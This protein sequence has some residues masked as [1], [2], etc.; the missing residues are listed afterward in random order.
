[1]LDAQA[2][3]L[4]PAAPPPT[5]A[6]AALRELPLGAVRPRGWLLDQ[7]R[8]QAD[9]LTG[10]LDDLWAD[11][12]PNSAWLGGGGEDWER[13]PYY[14]DGLLPLAHLLGDARLLAKAKVWVEAMLASQREDGFF[15]PPSNED[16]WP[17]MVALKVLAQHADATGDRRVVPFMTRY[18]RYQLAHLPHRPLFGWGQMRGADN[19]LSVYWLFERTGEA[20]LLDLARLL[21]EQ[22]ADWGEYLT[23]HLIDGPAREFSHLTHS[24]NVAM[25]LKTPALRFLLDGDERQ[26]EIT[27]AALANLDEKHGLVHGV[28]SGDEWLGGT[29]PHHGA[30]TCEVVEYM[31]T[32]EHLARVFGAGKYADRLETVAYSALP[33]S[34]TA[35]MTAHQYHQQANQVLVSVDTRDWSFSGDDANLFALEPHFGCCTANLHQGWPKFVRSLWMGTPGGGLAAVAYGPNEVTAELGGQRVRVTSET[36]YPFGE[37]VRLTVEAAAPARFPL[38][39]RVPGWCEGARVRLNGEATTL[40]PDGR[41]FVRLERE[42]RDGDTAELT[43]PMPVR[44]VE[45]ERGA[46]GLMVGP[47]VLAHSPGETWTR[48]SD[49]PPRPDSRFGDWEVRPRRSWNLGLFL[50][51]GAE[52]RVE[53]R[54]PSPVPFALDAAPLRVWARGAR[55]KSWGLALN[56][57]APP[58]ES[59]FTSSLPMDPVCLVPFGSA[60]LR[61]AEFPRLVPTGRVQGP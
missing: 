40:T 35:D 60:R 12:G 22:T 27:D 13:G 1:M 44:V 52:W 39:L 56:S 20:W 31:F 36:T 7:L 38:E 24:V 16:W 2:Q 33:A 26:R 23:E 18:F 43:F 21:F 19:V 8:L 46:C 10:H 57:A 5:L 51:P 6:P 4:S 32:L 58:P 34:C 3:P 17:R 30:E 9:G 48:V 55:I 29:E 49:D 54:P 15:G 41:G 50:D 25:G 59:P 28:F 45:R 61:V 11:V 14:L 37:T 42:W 53:R 47:L